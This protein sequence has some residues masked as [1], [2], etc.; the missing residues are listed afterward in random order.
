[1]DLRSR[2]FDSCGRFALLINSFVLCM[3]VVVFK[4]MLFVLSV[5]AVA[6]LALSENA[7]AQ[8]GPCSLD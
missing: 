3:E 8:S 4:K 2:L 6:T 1:M 5:L 7:M